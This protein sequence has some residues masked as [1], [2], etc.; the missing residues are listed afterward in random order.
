MPFIYIYTILGLKGFSPAFIAQVNDWLATLENN[1][2]RARALS[3]QKQRSHSGRSPRGT[4]RGRGRGLSRR[5]SGIGVEDPIDGI[6]PKTPL[7]RRGRGRGRGRGSTSTRG[8]R[9]LSNK[10]SS[11]RSVTWDLE[12]PEDLDVD[13]DHDQGF[14]RLVTDRD[15][16]SD[17][18]EFPS[19]DN[20]LDYDQDTDDQDDGDGDQDIDHDEDRDGD[21]SGDDDTFG[22]PSSVSKSGKR[23]RMSGG[24]IKSKVNGEKA[25]RRVSGPRKSLDK[26]KQ[27]ND[28]DE[29]DQADD[30]GDEAKDV[31]DT[32][33][34]DD[35]T[36][37]VVKIKK[38]R[39][40]RDGTIKKRK[41]QADG[42][43]DDTVNDEANKPAPEL[44]ENGEPIKKAKRKYVR[45]KYE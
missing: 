35:D 29:D 23:M 26:D 24:K 6:D 18:G 20:G 42:E 1:R 16:Y 11:N 36:D 5:L 12:D 25:L 19:T 27:K 40:P 34:I 21:D 37:K 45:R 30:L 9:I 28:D 31:E 8:R 13:D 17:E 10:D 43:N 41:K 39:K 14:D 44:D 7:V 22:K 32:A 2:R 15:E 33:G 3:D 38:T 4:G